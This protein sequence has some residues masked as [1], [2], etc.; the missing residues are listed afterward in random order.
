MRVENNFL[1]TDSLTSK[2]RTEIKL[3]AVQTDTSA[4][5]NAQQRENGC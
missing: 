2:D 5:A 3:L 1:D 4:A